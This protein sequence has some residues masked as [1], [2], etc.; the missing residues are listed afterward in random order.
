[1]IETVA[2]GSTVHSQKKNHDYACAGTELSLSVA[3]NSRIHTSCS[4]CHDALL[5]TISNEHQATVDMFIVF[6]G[7]NL[8]ILMTFCSTDSV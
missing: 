5:V 3:L 1:M 7:E 8:M 4:A 6:V 2:F